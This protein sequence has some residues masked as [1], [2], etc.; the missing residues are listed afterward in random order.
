MATGPIVLL[1]NDPTRGVDVGA[2]SEIYALCAELAATGLALLFTSSEIEETIGLCDRVKIM[3]KGTSIREFGKR[4]ADKA[5]VALW[6]SGGAAQQ[7]A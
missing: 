4:E 3:Y 5:D 7:T 1:L 2:K 6:I